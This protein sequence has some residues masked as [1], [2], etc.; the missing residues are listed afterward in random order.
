MMTD[1]LIKPT[2]ERLKKEMMRRVADG[3]FYVDYQT[4]AD[5]IY[6]LGYFTDEQM[7]ALDMYNLMHH[8]WAHLH[9]ARTSTGERV[10]S[11]MIN[12]S[13]ELPTLSDGYIK[14]K[15]NTSSAERRTLDHL[16]S[17][18]EVRY[19]IEL[20]R[21]SARTMAQ[22]S[23]FVLDLLVELVNDFHAWRKDAKNN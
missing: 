23:R 5:V 17:R 16:L 11:A 15:K 3:A 21:P 8:A 13:I 12:Y 2:P 10:E 14:I 20:Q 1:D 22:H 7:A 4:V 19:D 9:G 18:I 6:A